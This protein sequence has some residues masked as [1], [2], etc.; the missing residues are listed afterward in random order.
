MLFIFFKHQID[1][2]LHIKCNT[3]PILTSSTFLYRAY[4]LMSFGPRSRSVNIVA[5]HQ[6]LR[7]NFGA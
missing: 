5:L 4:S 7:L 6:T 1:L 3:S 2:R